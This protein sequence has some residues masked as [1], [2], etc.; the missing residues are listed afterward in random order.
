MPPYF[1]K[2]VRESKENILSKIQYPKHHRFSG[3]S[4]FCETA[5]NWK[6]LIDFL[7]CNFTLLY[8]SAVSLSLMFLKD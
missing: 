3:I 2:S 7:I 8:S 6:F 4:G 1:L 5:P